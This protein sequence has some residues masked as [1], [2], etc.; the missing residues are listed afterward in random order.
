MP[1]ITSIDDRDATAA[2][3]RRIME[4]PAQLLSNCVADYIVDQLHDNGN[5]PQNVA[6][7]GFTNV[8]Y[9]DVVKP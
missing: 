4:D 5:Q 1:P 6:I 7:P 2:R 8:S 9:P 3:L